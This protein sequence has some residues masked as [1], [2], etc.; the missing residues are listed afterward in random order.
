MSIEQRQSDAYRAGRDACRSD[1]NIVAC[2]LPPGRERAD[3]IAG[4][5]HENRERLAEIR[6][7]EQQARR[8]LKRP[9]QEDGW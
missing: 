3:W 1:Y 2:D 4:W 7:Q 8:G 9:K 6:R 5:H